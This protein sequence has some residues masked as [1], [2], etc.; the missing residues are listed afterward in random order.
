MSED[1]G[2]LEIVKIR[3]AEREERLKHVERLLNESVEQSK[4]LSS[5]VS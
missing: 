3:L 5:Q 1:Q 2:E 4:R